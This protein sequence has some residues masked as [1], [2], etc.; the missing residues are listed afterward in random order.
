MEGGPIRKTAEY[1]WDESGGGVSKYF[2]EPYWQQEA[3]IE[4]TT[5]SGMSTPTGRAVPDVYNVVMSPYGPS[6]WAGLWIYESTPCTFKVQSGAGQVTT[7]VLPGWYGVRGTSCGAPQWSAL[8]ADSL[9]AGISSGGLIAP[10]I[11]SH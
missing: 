7:Y 4:M 9:S 8:I 3:G 5:S 6:E 11:C 10:T 1:L 2:A